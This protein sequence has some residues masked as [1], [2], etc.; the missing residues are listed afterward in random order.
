MIGL[1]MKRQSRACSART[2]LLLLLLDVGGFEG[3]GGTSRVS[4]GIRRRNA[5]RRTI[6]TPDLTLE[7]Q[8][9]GRIERNL[10]T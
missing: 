9:I 5:I 1:M 7:T 8:S 4:R 6:L 10:L 2:K 3:E